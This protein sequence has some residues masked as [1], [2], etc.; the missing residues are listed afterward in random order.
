MYHRIA[1]GFQI[2]TFVSSISYFIVFI[3]LNDLLVVDIF[4]CG[5]GRLVASIGKFTFLI[6]LQ[7][8]RF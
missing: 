1:K 5:Y 7:L 2:T 4:G 6:C 8:F 3:D